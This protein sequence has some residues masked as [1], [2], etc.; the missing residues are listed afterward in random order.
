MNDGWKTKENLLSKSQKR[1]HSFINFKMKIL[2]GIDLIYT[3]HQCQNIVEIVAVI[4]A[5]TETWSSRIQEC[6]T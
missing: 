6:H 2:E 3:N 1:T 4:D 5:S